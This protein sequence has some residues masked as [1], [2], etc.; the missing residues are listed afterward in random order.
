MNWLK[1]ITHARKIITLY[2]ENYELI[3][4]ITL[5]GL[6]LLSLVLTWSLWTFKPSHP[7]I[8]DARTVKKQEVDD[9]AQSKEVVNPTQVIYHKGNKLFGIEANDT[10]K[11]FHNNLNETNF[12]IEPG[13]K[14]FV[15]FDPEEILFEGDPYI[16][17]IYP[18]R[19]TQEIYK[20]VFSIESEI[21]S[22]KLQYVDVDRIFLYQN[23]K[24]SNIEGYLVSYQSSKMQKI[25][26]SNN[27]L[28]PLIKGMDDMVKNRKLVPYIAYDIEQSDDARN[29][30]KRR[31]Y[32]PKNNLKLN[33][34]N[35]IS[36]PI[37]EDTY[38][39]YKQALF[40]DP[41]AVK[42]ATGDNEIT[43]ADGTTALVVNKLRNRFEYTNFAGS[44]NP[45]SRQISP[46]FQSIEYINTHAGWG[47][48]YRISN[49]ESDITDF[50]LFVEN[51]PVLERDMQMSLTWD[52]GELQKYERSLVQLDLSASSFTEEITLQSG[53][54]VVRELKESDYNGEYIMGLRIGYT[55]KKRGSHLYELEP[56]WFFNYGINYDTNGWQPLFKEDREEGF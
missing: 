9:P 17:V 39:M 47:N 3:K 4:S 41:Q 26:A 37:S 30:I 21:V 33:S 2:R 42:S 20:D 36:R 50:W 52:K 54:A 5:T 27:N 16:E 29:A 53:E 55:M 7:L 22:T 31:F 25:K 6:I 24:T 49:L 35:Y 44:T 43:Y 45:N 46:L 23:E 11:E 48:P 10:I 18:V 14:N 1:W 40:K 19:M 15:S 28:L 12:T 38:E 32:L 34:Y 56:K 51:L 13:V 8:E